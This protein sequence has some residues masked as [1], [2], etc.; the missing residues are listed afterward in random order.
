[1]DVRISFR[2]LD[3][4]PAFDALIREKINHLER[5]IDGLVR[6][7]VHFDEERNPKLTD[8]KDVC[9]VTLEGG[10]HHVRCKVSGPDPTTALDRAIDRLEQQLRRAKAKSKLRHRQHGNHESIRHAGDIDEEIAVADGP[11][12]VKTKAFS[13]DPMTVDD[14]VLKMEML[15]HD[16]F[17][18]QNETTN[19]TAVVYLRD[20]GDVGLI[21][22]T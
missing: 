15:G 1:M 20:D 11:R 21:D 13:L 14:A 22:A 7:E 18:F 2:H 4:S 12:I 9:E 8:S 17:V 5:F 19:R 6:A 3:H 16:F 10:G